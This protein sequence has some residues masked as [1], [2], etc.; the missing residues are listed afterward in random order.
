MISLKLFRYHSPINFNKVDV[1]CITSGS[2]VLRSVPI[3]NTSINIER[4]RHL[5]DGQ[6]HIGVE[7]ARYNT[8][9][10]LM[11]EHFQEFL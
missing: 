8:V 2:C 11:K 9:E 4:A 5:L 7:L 1:L 6:G 10:E 3:E